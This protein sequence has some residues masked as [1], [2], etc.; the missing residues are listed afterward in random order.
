MTRV[1]QTAEEVQKSLR[2]ASS[3]RKTPTHS[4]LS[5][6]VPQR[7]EA[8]HDRDHMAKRQY[9]LVY[10]DVGISLDNAPDLRSFLY[11]LKDVVIGTFGSVTMIS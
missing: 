5:G 1:E 10:K 2:E 8:P 4:G 3:Y 7:N 9:R 6:S 11:A